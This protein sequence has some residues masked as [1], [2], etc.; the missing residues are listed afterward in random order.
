[1]W[2][3]RTYTNSNAIVM[4][5]SNHDVRTCVHVC[6]LSFHV[7]IPVKYR[8]S[9]MPFPFQL[10][11][12]V[13]LKVFVYIYIYSI[14]IH[15]WM[16]IDHLGPQSWVSPLC[17]VTLLQL[18]YTCIFFSLCWGVSAKKMEPRKIHRE[19]Q[20]HFAISLFHQRLLTRSPS[21]RAQLLVTGC[22]LFFILFCETKLQKFWSG[23]MCLS[24]PGAVSQYIR[25]CWK[26]RWVIFLNWHYALNFFRGKKVKKQIRHIFQKT[27]SEHKGS[28]EARW[29]GAS[30]MVM[31]E[32]DALS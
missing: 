5:A 2:Q 28:Q 10:N 9:E 18:P 12:P 4:A 1:M 14:R 23:N 26:T 32:H 29:T 13:W 17:S 25:N 7:R 30:T 8:K 11:G 27:V 21:L 6:A 22:C 19:S 24:Q 31:S 3:L 15:I 20:W 16:Y